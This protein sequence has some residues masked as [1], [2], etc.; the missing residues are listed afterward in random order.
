METNET[1]YDRKIQ[2]DLK[3]KRD[4]PEYS[5]YMDRLHRHK[6]LKKEIV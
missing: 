6:V 5:P 2:K 1:S 4:E 3:K